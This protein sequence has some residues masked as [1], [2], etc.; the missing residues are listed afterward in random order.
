MRSDY[1]MDREKEGKLELFYAL[2]K[3]LTT[4]QPWFDNFEF[5]S[6][7]PNPKML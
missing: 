6:N 5:L 4:H 7:C 1:G 3:R 2:L